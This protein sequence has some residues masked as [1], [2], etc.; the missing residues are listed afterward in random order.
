MFTL[1][2]VLARPSRL[3]GLDHRA[4]AIELHEGRSSA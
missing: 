4:L 2:G 1:G 3:I